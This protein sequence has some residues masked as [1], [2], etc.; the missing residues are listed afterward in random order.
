MTVGLGASLC[1]RALV[2]TQSKRYRQGTYGGYGMA[3]LFEKR[4][5]EK[6]R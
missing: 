1:L 3:F 5:K 4:S 6:S 2:R